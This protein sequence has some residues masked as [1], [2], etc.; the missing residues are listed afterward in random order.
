MR[1]STRYL[2]TVGPKQ[3]LK[4]LANIDGMLGDPT[5]DTTKEDA[6]AK[7]A[8]AHILLQEELDKM[9][10]EEVFALF[11]SFVT[12]D[13]IIKSLSARIAEQ[14]ETIGHITV[15]DVWGEE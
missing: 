10:K 13:G 4:V 11:S 5:K 15:R 3:A 1:D 12:L 9:S 6:K 8:L 14:L 2:V 7:G